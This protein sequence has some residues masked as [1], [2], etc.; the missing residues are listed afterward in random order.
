MCAEF[1]LD[2]ELW[3]KCIPT[4]AFKHGGQ[5]PISHLAFADDSI[6][7]NEHKRDIESFTLFI[8]FYKERWSQVVKK[9]KKGFV[10]A[11]TALSAMIQIW[12]GLRDE[13][14]LEVW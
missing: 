1:Y 5:L 14:G 7:S 9:K 4:F 3:W 10:V 13:F 2:S 12:K 6:F 11:R 8:S